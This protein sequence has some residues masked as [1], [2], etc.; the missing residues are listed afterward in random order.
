MVARAPDGSNSLADLFADRRETGETTLGSASS[1]WSGCSPYLIGTAH[2]IAYWMTA[3]T[4][5][6]ALRHQRMI[7]WD[8]DID[9]AMTEE[10][11]L[12]FTTVAC[13]LPPDIFFQNS[14]TDPAYPHG[15]NVTA[16]L[17]DRY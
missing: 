1:C 7:P 6:G 8:D 12:A 11:Y 2:G 14:E 17:R 4:L 16:K 10:D 5:I 3:G 15:M 13:D 9:V